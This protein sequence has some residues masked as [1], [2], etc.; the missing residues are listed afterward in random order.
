MPDSDPQSVDM[1]ASG[2]LQWQGKVFVCP[3]PKGKCENLCQ[4]DDGSMRMDPDHL[5]MNFEWHG[6]KYKDDC[7]GFENEPDSGTF[8]RKRVVGISFLPLIP[9]KYMTLVGA[10]AVGNQAAQFKAA[11]RIATNYEGV[12]D[13]KVR[14]SADQG[15]LTLV[16][17]AKGTYEFL[18]DKSGV[19]ELVF[20]L[21]G[22]DG[23]AFHTDRMRIEIPAIPGLGR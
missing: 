19:Y 17:A 16:D 6:K 1:Q 4:W 13:A 9:G 7:S 15:K 5:T 22:S 20:E 12:P 8:T 3:L 21:V 2:S 23:R 10:P 11:V 18:A 14:A